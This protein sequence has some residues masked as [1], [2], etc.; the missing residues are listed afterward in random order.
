MAIFS[1]L[2]K[3]GNHHKKHNHINNNI[4]K[5]FIVFGTIFVIYIIQCRLSIYLY[6]GNKI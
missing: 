2:E 3:K 6:I 4:L 5:R 1:I